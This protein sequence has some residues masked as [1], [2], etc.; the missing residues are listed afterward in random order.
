MT[1]RDN[2]YIDIKCKGRSKCFDVLTSEDLEELEKTKIIVNYKKG[3]VL[4]KQGSANTNILFLKKGYVKFYKEFTS[5]RTLVSIEKKCNLIGLDGLFVNTIMQHTLEALTDCIVCSFDNSLFEKLINKN[6][7]FAA[8][9]IKNINKKGVSNFNNMANSSS[10]Q[11]TGRIAWSLLILSTDV[12]DSN[13]IMSFITRKDLAEFSNMS[14]MSV[15]RVLREFN[16]EKVIE[17]KKD[18]I[19]ILDKNKLMV[20]Y[21]NG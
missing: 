4:A 14:V 12:F 16:E 17:L 5:T 13:E 20:A 21:K 9:T 19:C 2:E 18:R 8:E 7:K 3:E 6:S 15:G 1:F 11:L 10:K